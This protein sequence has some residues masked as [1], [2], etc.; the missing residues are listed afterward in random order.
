MRGRPGARG[1]GARD[2]RS[3][4]RRPSSAPST[5]ARC[6]RTWSGTSTA[7]SRCRPASTSTSSCSRTV[8]RRSRRCSKRRAATRRTPATRRS[9]CPTR[10]TPSGSPQ[11]LAGD[12]PTVVYFGKLIEQK[13]VQVLLEAMHDVDAR[14]VVVGF[15][16]YRATLEA[17]RAAAD[18]L[19]RP[20]RAPPPRAPAA[21]RRRH[22]RA[23]DLPRGVRHGRRRGCRRGLAAARRAALRPRRGRGRPRGGVPGAL[24]PP[25]LVRDRRRR[26]PAREARTS[27]SRCRRPIARRSGWPRGAPSSSAGRGRASRSGCS[28]RPEPPRGLRL[29]PMGEE[30]RV[31]WQELLATCREAFEA[32]TDFTLAVEEE[33]ALLDPQTLELTDRFEELYAAATQ[34]DLKPHIVGELI[35]SE[36]EVRTGRCED[37]GEAAA[38]MQE[39]RGQLHGLAR[40]LHSRSAPPARI[41]GAAGRTSGSSTRRTTGG[42]TSSSATSSGGTTPSACTCTSGSRAPTARSRCTTRCATSCPSCSRSPRARRSSRRS[43]PACTRRAPRS[44]RACSRAAASRTPY[45]ELAGLRG[46]R[47]VPLPHRLDHRAHADLVERAAAPRLPDRRDPHLRR[48]ARPRRGA[49][50]RRALL[51]ARRALCARARRGRDAAEPAAPPARGEHVAGDPLRPLRRAARLRARRVRSR[52]GRGSS[53]CSSG[54]SP[55]AEEIGAAPFLAIP[56]ATP[57]S[58]RSPGSRRAAT[59][60]EIYA[61]QVQAGEPIGG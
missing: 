32:G 11:F 27:C 21:A 17:A 4:P 47:L 51:R 38:A 50:A 52:P 15:G 30:Q 61:E 6:S 42:T 43:T 16:P 10:A 12:E 35:A 59:L 31:S 37:F 23:V 26:R 2:A 46:L 39:R 20:A 25:G 54:S 49:V 44:S 55:V 53:S 40:E 48:P 5:S 28:H 36:I 9:G 7:S 22:R 19:H 8:A 3:A 60:Q 57:P 29:P 45:G 34:T 41:R 14:L 58:A 33:F 24:A 13:G 56:S 1:V 18:A